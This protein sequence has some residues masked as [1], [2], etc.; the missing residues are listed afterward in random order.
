MVLHLQCFM[1]AA[2]GVRPNMGSG[3]AKFGSL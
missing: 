2:V 1:E 3:L